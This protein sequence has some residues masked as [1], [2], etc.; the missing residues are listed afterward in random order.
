[1]IHDIFISNCPDNKGLAKLVC[2]ALEANGLKCWLRSRDMNRR[3]DPKTSIEKAIKAASVMMIVFSTETNDYPG[4]AS[5]MNIAINSD[6]HLIPIRVEM[7]EP[8]GVMDYYL[9]DT[10]WFD[11]TDPPSEKSINDLILIVKRSLKD[12]KEQKSLNN[13]PDQ[14]KEAKIVFKKQHL[15]IIKALAAI[16]LVV[17]FLITFYGFFRLISGLE[18]LM[19]SV[20]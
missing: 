17:G 15:T 7:A 12:K 3:N 9:A 6:L 5:E 2:G 11:V 14:D 16:T 10:Q 19:V 18:R 20:F 13:I 1:M 4:L 8:K